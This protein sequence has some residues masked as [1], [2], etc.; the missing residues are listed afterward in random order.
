MVSTL[1]LGKSPGD[2]FP[3]LSALSFTS[4]QWQLALLES[5]EEGIFSTKEC[6]GRE[7]LLRDCCLP[8]VQATNRAIL[9]RTFT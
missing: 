7:D 9:N 6:A 8:S 4:K 5:V 1:F 3:V 2:R